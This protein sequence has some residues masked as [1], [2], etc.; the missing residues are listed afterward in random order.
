M[1]RR[2]LTSV[3]AVACCCAVARGVRAEAV[4][5][6]IEGADAVNVRRGP[7]TESPAFAFITK[8]TRVRVEAI[9]GQWAQIVL[10]SGQRGYVN[11]AY[12]KLPPG[13]TVGPANPTAPIAEAGQP[14]AL[15]TPAPGTIEPTRS[16]DEELAEM[17]KR[18]AVLESSVATPALATSVPTPTSTPALEGLP[19]TPLAVPAPSGLDDVGPTLALAGV[20]LVIGFGIGTLYGQR[21][22]RRRRSRV[23]F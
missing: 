18:L 3:L 14:A 7:G 23:R 21:Q 17:R 2:I 9:D 16:V 1:P 5:A 10:S 20:C 22:E 4:S 6:V 13:V 8:G 19:P 15:E 12:V 11:A